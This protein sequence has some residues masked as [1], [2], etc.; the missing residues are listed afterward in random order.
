MH[1]DMPPQ[2]PPILVLYIDNNRHRFYTALK[3]SPP[4][5]QGKHRVKR[6]LYR[7]VRKR[8]SLALPCWKLAGKLAIYL[9][10]Q[11]QHFAVCCP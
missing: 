7:P 6:I 2:W 4:A 11:H 3:F 1:C 8:L 5:K 9:F 10:V